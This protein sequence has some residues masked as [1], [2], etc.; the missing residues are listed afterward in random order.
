MKLNVDTVV[1]MYY[2]MG[3]TSTQV[4]LVMADEPATGRGHGQSGKTHRLLFTDRGNNV[5][6]RG[7][8]SVHRGKGGKDEPPEVSR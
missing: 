4:A 7:C 2:R 3:A 1:F 6:T 5:F 8:H